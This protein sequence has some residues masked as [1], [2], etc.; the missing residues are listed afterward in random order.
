VLAPI[1]RDGEVIAQSLQRAGLEVAVCL[2]MDELCRAIQAGAEMAIVGE[3]ALVHESVGRLLDVLERLPRWSDPPIVVL[4]MPGSETDAVIFERLAGVNL[5][6]VERPMRPVTLVAVVR[7]S[8]RN[9]ARQHGTRE[10]L[11]E[12]QRAREELARHSERLAEAVQKRTEELEAVNQTLRLA[13]RMAAIGTLSAGVGHDIA[14]LLMPLRVHLDTLEAQLGGEGRPVNE[15]I[16]AIRVCVEHLQRLSSGLRQLAL[17]PNSDS[18]AGEA[19]HV[20]EWWADAEPLLRNALP[21][22]VR[23]ESDF[24][25]GDEGPPDVAVS[26]HQLTQAVFNLVQ[27]AGD[28]MRECQRGCVTVR[29]RGEDAGKRV[30]VSVIDNGPGMSDEVRGRCLE[31]LFT[32]KVRQFS[33]GLGLVIVQGIVR[34]AGGTLELESKVGVGTTFSMVFPAARVHAGGDA[35]SAEPRPVAAVSVRDPR[36]AGLVSSALRSMGFE[37]MRFENGRPSAAL[38]IADAS[39]VTPE[40]VDAFVDG[41]PER[42]VVVFGGASEL[43][44]DPRV[45]ATSER[46]GAAELREVLRAATG[47]GPRE[48]MRNERT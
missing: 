14:N 42:R 12:I 24:G 47:R 18:S 37:A 41:V 26:P 2:S 31:P 33:T 1:G 30:R 15:G 29:A 19:L 35:G 39:A 23:L 22:N 21:R 5:T 13:E 38:W 8:L 9:R 11:E 36:F 25:G 16:A 27:N 43:S 10:Q 45:L 4:E 32:T 6:L 3:E 17:D 44:N 46:P 40:A 20:R 34:R 48:A 7:S 28:V